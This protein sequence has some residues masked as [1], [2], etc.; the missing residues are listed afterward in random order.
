MISWPLLIF[1]E[2]L[3]ALV[4]GILNRRSCQSSPFLA[5]IHSRDSDT[6]CPP[7]TLGTPCRKVKIRFARLN[8]VLT[9]KLWK[10]NSR[11]RKVE[12]SKSKIIFW[13][14][15]RKLV[16]L[17]SKENVLSKSQKCLM[18]PFVVNTPSPCSL[19]W[20][21]CVISQQL[22]FQFICSILVS[23]G[24]HRWCIGARSWDWNRTNN[25]FVLLLLVAWY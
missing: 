10:N 5:L 23:S 24:S 3:M 8:L 25:A 7:Q 11:S 15:C 18:F 17:T 9:W 12:K 13:S 4:T 1:I 2:L 19:C 6:R 20:Y 22:G 16:D 21:C 14:N